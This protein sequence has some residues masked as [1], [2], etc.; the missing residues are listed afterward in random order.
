MCPCISSVVCALQPACVCVMV[1][2]GVAVQD[3]CYKLAVTD[4]GSS[5]SLVSSGTSC[6]SIMVV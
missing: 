1:L 3:D 2:V 6:M 4:S 5:K